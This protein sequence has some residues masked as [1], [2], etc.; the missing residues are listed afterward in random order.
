MELFLWKAILTKIN[1]KHV[2]KV[3]YESTNV[4]SC[5]AYLKRKAKLMVQISSKHVFHLRILLMLSNDG[6]LNKNVSFRMNEV[7]S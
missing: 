5:L 2:H 6:F 1:E 3:S 7:I 4:L